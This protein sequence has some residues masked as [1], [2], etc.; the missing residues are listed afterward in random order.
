MRVS[1]RVA[2]GGHD[3]CGFLPTRGVLFQPLGEISAIEIIRDD[4][5]LPVLGAGVMDRH[6][7]RVMQPGELTSLLEQSFGFRLRNVRAEAKHLD[8]DRTVELRVVAEVHG[9]ETAGP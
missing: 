4:E 1:K 6:D 7:A 3:G 5:H 9:T 2:H 8:G